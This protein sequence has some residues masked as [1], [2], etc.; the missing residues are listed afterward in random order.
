MPV[1][2]YMCVDVLKK[3]CAIEKQCMRKKRKRYKWG[4][5]KS[6][7]LR[8]VIRHTVL[9]EWGI[10]KNNGKQRGVLKEKVRDKVREKMR[11][12]Q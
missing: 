12:L 5:N 3:G 1:F 11:V 7:S 10:R 6:E 9:K 8:S 4:R 2:T